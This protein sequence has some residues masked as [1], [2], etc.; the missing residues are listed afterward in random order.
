LPTIE[1]RLR[2]Y[3]RSW[4]ADELRRA[5]EQPGVVLSP[6]QQKVFGELCLGKSTAEI[7]RSL[8]RSEYT[9]SN[10]IKEICK[11]YNV[12]SRVALLAKAARQVR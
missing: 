11:A 9:I 2:H 8:V 12:R 3:Q 6:M 1:E 5:I 4:L 7:A 10:H